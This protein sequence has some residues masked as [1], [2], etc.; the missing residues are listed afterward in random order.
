MCLRCLI[1]QGDDQLGRGLDLAREYGQV[2]YDPDE[3]EWF[4]PDDAVGPKL[5]RVS[6][7]DAV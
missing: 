1:E 4:V 5:E 7:S 3:G 2:D 6:A